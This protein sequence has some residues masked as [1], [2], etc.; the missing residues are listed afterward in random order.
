MAKL[1]PSEKTLKR[2]LKEHKIAQ[3]DTL[4]N[5]LILAATHMIECG[6]TK[7]DQ[8]DAAKE[9]VWRIKREIMDIVKS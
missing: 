8:Y 3:I 2:E 5:R 9:D 6:L 1:S 7:K 4:C